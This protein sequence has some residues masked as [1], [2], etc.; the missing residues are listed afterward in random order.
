[1]TPTTTTITVF[2]IRAFENQTRVPIPLMIYFVD[3]LITD[4]DEPPVIGK[5]DPVD[6]GFK[7][8]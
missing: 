4:Q 1:M 2:R 3:I 5:P 7:E 8:R 6:I